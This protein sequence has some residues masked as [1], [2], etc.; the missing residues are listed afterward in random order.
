[1]K[2]AVMWGLAIGIAAGTLQLIDTAIDPLADDTAGGMLMIVGT[3]LILWTAA[4]YFAARRADRFR[5]AVL[6]GLLVG[7]A[8]ICVLHFAAIVRVNLFLD[9]IQYREDWTNLVARFH[10]SRF[11]SL[12]A[13]ANYEYLTGTWLLLLIGAAA[14][15]ICGIVSGTI[16]AGV[17]RVFRPGSTSRV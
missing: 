1:M 4:S 13:Y 14:G 2:H 10:A 11:Q 16:S 9:Q 7:L 5:D 3:L 17:G 12:R 8:S 15:S 6:A